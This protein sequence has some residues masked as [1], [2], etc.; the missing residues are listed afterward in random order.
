MSWTCYISKAAAATVRAANIN[1]QSLGP[2]EENAYRCPLLERRRR[3]QCAP[4][5]RW[6]PWSG[7]AIRNSPN[8]ACLVFV[9]ARLEEQRFAAAW[10]EILCAG[11]ILW[12]ISAR[13]LGQKKSCPSNLGNAAI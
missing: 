12:D 10:V 4:L 5:L 11:R 3:V 6:R 9:R 7:S 2:D 1:C 13:R 8:H